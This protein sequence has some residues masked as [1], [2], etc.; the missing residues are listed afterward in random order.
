MLLARA[1]LEVNKCDIYGYTPLDCAL[2]GIQRLFQ[3]P[4]T[5]SMLSEDP[6]TLLASPK[7]LQRVLVELGIRRRI[8]EILKAHNAISFASFSTPGPKTVWKDSQVKP[9]NF[10]KRVHE[11]HSKR[12]LANVVSPSPLTQYEFSA[13]STITT[14]KTKRPFS[15][16][17]SGNYTNDYDGTP[18]WYRSIEGKMPPPSN[19]TRQ[20][21]QAPASLA[22]SQKIQALWDHAD[23]LRGSPTTLNPSV[24]LPSNDPMDIFG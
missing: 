7:D 16:I 17:S 20:V 5:L 4:D 22:L 2:K 15:R 6:G 3:P 18:L 24:N 12:S 1:D 21:K 10:Q 13:S 11:L 23:T 19:I 14:E 9:S 8:V